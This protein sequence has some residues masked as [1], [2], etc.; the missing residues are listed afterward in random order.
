[1]LLYFTPVLQQSPPTLLLYANPARK[2]A[3]SVTTEHGFYPIT[4]HSGRG[5]YNTGG[6]QNE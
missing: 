5:F 3:L 2:P 4:I 6:K 1:M